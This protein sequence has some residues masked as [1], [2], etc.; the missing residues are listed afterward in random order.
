MGAD[1]PPTTALFSS[2]FRDLDSDVNAVNG[3]TSTINQRSNRSCLSFC[4]HHNLKA[5]ST[6]NDQK[7]ILS[8]N[9]CSSFPPQAQPAIELEIPLIS[10]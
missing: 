5:Y 3:T 9:E 1:W 2:H 6:T 7:L 10:A 4:C 8:H